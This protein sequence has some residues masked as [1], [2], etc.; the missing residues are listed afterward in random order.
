MMR[1]RA[2]FPLG[3]RRLYDR[4]SSFRSDLAD[5]LTVTAHTAAALQSLSGALR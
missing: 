5:R 4:P 1:R 2:S 3:F